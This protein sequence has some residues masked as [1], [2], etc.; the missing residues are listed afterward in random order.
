MFNAEK[1]GIPHL[2]NKGSVDMR[3]AVDDTPL[4]VYMLGPRHDTDS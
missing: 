4:L 3:I 1:E 2:D